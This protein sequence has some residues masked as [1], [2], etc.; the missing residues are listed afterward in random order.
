MTGKEFG[1]WMD[2]SEMAL[3]TAA[4]YFGVSEGTIY[5]WRSTPGVPPSREEWVRARMREFTN[6]TENIPLPDR[7]TLEVEPQT[8]DQWNRAAMTEGK[9]LREWAIA[10]LNEAAEA[11]DSTGSDEP[12]HPL[13]HLPQAPTLKAAE[14]GT[15]D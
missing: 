11:D 12:P 3:D 15:E 8:F 4:A 14:P 5:K 9:L 2:S 7:V 1:E 6:G 13:Y 10:V